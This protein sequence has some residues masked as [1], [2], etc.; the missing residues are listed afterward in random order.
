MAEIISTDPLFL[1]ARSFKDTRR[2]ADRLAKAAYKSERLA[3]V[4][5][6]LARK[7]GLDQEELRQVL[8]M[9]L[10]QSL[11]RGEA[12]FASDNAMYS[13]LIRVGVHFKIKESRTTDMIVS[14]DEPAS[15]SEEVDHE[16]RNLFSDAGFQ[17]SS[18]EEDIDRNRIRPEVR[19]YRFASHSINRMLQ[20]SYRLQGMPAK[21]ST[22]KAKEDTLKITSKPS[23]TKASKPGQVALRGMSPHLRGFPIT[24]IPPDIE[25][26]QRRGRPAGQTVSKTNE[27]RTPAQAELFGYCEESGLLQ[28][29][30]AAKIGLTPATL[31][32]YIYARTKDVPAAV[33]T[34]A[35][36][37]AAINKPQVEALKAKF[38]GTMNEIIS[39]W[40]K[41]ISSEPFT[42]SKLAK[43]LEVDETT[44][45]RWRTKSKPTTRS[46]ARYELKLLSHFKK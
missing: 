9:A 15:G 33:L 3:N 19:A 2:G 12:T 5:H 10:L 32:A 20:S 6:Y 7:Q 8:T 45:M 22:T 21:V 36:E 41:E 40:E 17:A 31:K 11:R 1:A 18:V 23:N 27:R 26:V 30:Y 4:T 35:R 29:D 34:A 14:Y 38:S 16:H 46:L 43:I 39:R 42:A 24:M 13:Y 37:H 25:S 44:V 28:S